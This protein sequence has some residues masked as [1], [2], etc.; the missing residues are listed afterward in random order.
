MHMFRDKRGIELGWEFIFTLLF[1]IAIIIIISI[2]IGSQASGS[3]IKK[4]ILAKE[5][6]MLVT[7]A[8]PETTIIIEHEKSIII[9]KDRTGIRVK[10][11][12][13]DRGYLYYC[14]LEDNVEF[15]RKDQFTVIEIR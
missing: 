2:W 8:E 14:Y 7:S 1:V 9:E 6:C 11:G 3:A 4:Q 10:E 13:F 15:S 12:E 5:V